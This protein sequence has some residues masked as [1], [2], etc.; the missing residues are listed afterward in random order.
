MNKVLLEQINGNSLRTSKVLG[1]TDQIPEIGKSFNMIAQSLNPE[2]TLRIIT[3]STVK[4]LIK[5]QYGSEFNTQNS[6]YR[7]IWL[8]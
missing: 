1:L 4:E 8:L 6:K 2:K 3:T 7:L 5:S